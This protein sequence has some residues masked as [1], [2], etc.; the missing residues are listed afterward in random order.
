MP[1][2]LYLTDILQLVVDGL[3]QGS[4]AQHQVIED[5]LQA[6]LHILLDLR[7]QLQVLLL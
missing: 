3:D 6:V 7:N 4:L 1:R 5:R 2:V